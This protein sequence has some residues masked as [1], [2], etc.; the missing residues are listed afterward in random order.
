ME[1]EWISTG[2]AARLLGYSP[3]HFRRKFMGI[4]PSQRIPGCHRRWLR[5]AVEKL[6]RGDDSLAHAG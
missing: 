4:I 3:D 6:A 5:E 1:A 2:K